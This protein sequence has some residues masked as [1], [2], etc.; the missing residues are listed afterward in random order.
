MY[1][2]DKL[3]HNQVQLSFDNMIHKQVNRLVLLMVSMFPI[4]IESMMEI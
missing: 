1:I 3:I 2:E 4:D